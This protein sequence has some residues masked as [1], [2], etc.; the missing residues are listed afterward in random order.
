MFHCPSSKS[1][2]AFPATTCKVPS[3]THCC[4][5]TG[6]VLQS[7][8]MKRSKELPAQTSDSV[9]TVPSQL[10]I[11]TTDLQ[12]PFASEEKHRSHLLLDHQNNSRWST[13][14]YDLTR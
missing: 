4:L 8:S 12:K 9:P 13:W 7:E 11:C 5:Y 10:C 14:A 3:S 6:Q 1:A 2:A